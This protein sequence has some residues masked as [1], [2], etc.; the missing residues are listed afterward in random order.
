M[1]R[2]KPSARIRKISVRAVARRRGVLPFASTAFRRWLVVL[3]MIAG[4]GPI[5]A[6]I[7]AVIEEYQRKT[8]DRRA[9]EAAQARETAV[10]NPGM[11]PRPFP[12]GEAIS[13]EAF[14]RD[15]ARS[16]GGAAGGNSSPIPS[17]VPAVAAHV[18]RA[19]GAAERVSGATS[20][21]AGDF[22]P[23]RARLAARSTPVVP[24]SSTTVNGPLVIDAANGNSP[25]TINAGDALTVTGTTYV[26][27][28]STG[29]VNQ[30]GG[31]FEAKSNQS[32]VL[33]LNVPASGT[34]NLNGGT[35]TTTAVL[36][37]SGSATFNFNGGTLAASA[38]NSNFVG[39][40]TTANVRGG[41]AVID[42]N[43]F[44]VTIS[45][46][47]AHSTL[48]GDAATDGGLTKNGAGTLMLTGANTY[49]GPTTI[50]AG[51]LAVASSASIG[52]SSSFPNGINF[53][54]TLSD[55]TSTLLATGDVLVTRNLTV[56]TDATATSVF[57]TAILAA[58]PGKT[59]NIQSANITLH[60]NT[61]LVFG[62]EGNTGTVAL[63]SPIAYGIQGGTFSLTVAAGTLQAVGDFGVPFLT[64]YITPTVVNAGAVLDFNGYDAHTTTYAGDL[65]RTLL[66][67]GTV[68]TGGNAATNITVDSG[69]FAG[70][71][72]GPGQ[73]T[74]TSYQT[75][76]LSGPS[77]YAGGTTV[78][79]GALIV[80]N[81][82]GSGTG[83]GPVLVN[84]GILGGQG[85]IGNQV[86]L[87]NGST[88]APGSPI[89]TLST[90]AL[91]MRAG[92]TLSIDL[93]PALVTGSGDHD[94]VDV[95][96]A[97]TLEGCNLKL[98]ILSAPTLGERFLLVLND[99][100]D[101]VQG[102]F[103]QGATVSA[104]LGGQ[105]YLF[106]IDYAANGDGGAIGNDIALTAVSVPEPSPWAWC[107]VGLLA[108]GV[109]VLRRRRAR[110]M[111]RG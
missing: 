107:G 108:G 3:L 10:G 51:T 64:S 102:A 17:V 94:Q 41:G 91:K 79:S 88:L 29:I 48:A 68:L 43:G 20:S 16:N 87:E 37:G 106:A 65:V 83:T 26:G 45:Q 8:A 57:T 36:R 55:G 54:G 27:Y 21:Q 58:A 81:T 74:K 53:N 14:R 109:A 25:Y 70:V 96:G 60:S 105:I 63:G 28:N 80:N 13:G 100:M 24:G 110:G 23:A 19:M 52:G 12:A 78:S 62:S 76:V 50:N 99:G 73:I 18:P 69:N 101:P 95:T 85:L 1:S 92:S 38:D 61:Q 104:S 39:G 6:G 84:A 9:R 5:K 71:I 44:N 22:H 75:L 30:N 59:L 77:V 103:A 32:L 40:L 49:T 35:L 4:A 82:T 34:Y 47:L 11:I 111:I 46:G 15:S 66:G 93:D 86:T 90:G 89:G 97:L 56:R 98:N 33:G 42:T 72:G 31:T 7:H 67:S 2:K